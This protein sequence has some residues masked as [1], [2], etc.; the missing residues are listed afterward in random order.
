MLAV[1]VAGVCGTC[2]AHPRQVPC[3]WYTATGERLGTFNGHQGAVW[4]LDVN[5]DTTRLLTGS[6]DTSARIWDCETGKQVCRCARSFGLGSLQRPAFPPQLCELKHE[7]MVRSVMWANGDRMVLTV[8]DQA[9]SK[10][11]TIFI[12]NVADDPADRACSRLH[13]ASA[14]SG[15]QC[16][17]CCCCA[18]DPNPV[19]A[20]TADEIKIKMGT[21]LWGGLNETII[22]GGDDGCIRVWDVEKGVQINKVCARMGRVSRWKGG[23]T[24]RERTR[25]RMRKCLFA[26]S[27][28]PSE[29]QQHSVLA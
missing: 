28:A 25:M 27:S 16:A 20:M 11:P 19:R 7:A 9:F 6:S 18:E 2:V 26:D 8:Q 29:D 17:R 1:L 12:Y 14:A 22:S 15:A 10:K 13:S 24:D 3:A 23:P 5:Y 4:T 21:A